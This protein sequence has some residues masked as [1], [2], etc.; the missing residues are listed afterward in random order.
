MASESAPPSRQA[1]SSFDAPLGTS[2][3]LTAVGAPPTREPD[4]GVTPSSA[5]GRLTTAAALLVLAFLAIAYGTH[6]PSP[7]PA[8]A[9]PSEFS[10]ERAMAHVQQIS[11][12]PHPSGSADHAR[13]REYVMTELRALGLTPAIQDVTG[14][15][16]RYAVAGRVQNVVVRVPGTASDGRAVLVM[17]HYDGVGAGPAAGDDGAGVA[18][19]LET[20]RAIRAGAPLA[21]DVIALF[22]D[23]EEDGLLGAAA[24][25][26][27]HPWMKDAA[28][29]LNFDSRGDEGPAYMFETGPGNLGVVRV[30]RHVSGV[31]A[32]SL[33]TAVYRQLPNDTDLSEIMPLGLQAMNFGYIGRVDHYHTSQDDPTRL[34]RGTLQ[35]YGSQMLALAR[36]FGSGPLPMS[37][38]SDAVFFDFPGLG[39]IV[40]GE[41]WALPLAIVALLLVAIAVGR[42]VRRR[43]PGWLRGIL[44][45]V[46]GTIASIVLASAAAYGFSVAIARMHASLGGTPE[47]STVYL[48]AATLLVIAVVAASYAFVRRWATPADALIGALV[49]WALLAVIVSALAPGV[50]FL[51]AWPLLAATPAA[52]QAAE[53]GRPGPASR[54]IAAFV[55]IFLF[56]PTVYGIV[57]IALGLAG[58]GTVAVGVLGALGGWLIVPLLET[59]GGA[60]RW[61]TALYALAGCVVMSCVG[62]AT[63]R[64]TDARPVGASLVYAADADGKAYV[65]GYDFGRPGRRWVTDAVASLRAPTSDAP[66]W[67]FFAGARRP[68]A[69]APSPST[70]LEAPTGTIVSDS[71]S[72]DRRHV[73][74][75]VRAAA[76]TLNV[77]MVADSGAVLASAVDGRPVDAQRYRRPSARWVLQY[78]APPESGFLLVLTM[79]AGTHPAID[80]TARSSGIPALPGVTLPARPAGVIP[81]QTGDM[82]VVHRR[83]VL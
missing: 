19:M 34:S 37:R 47:F 36:A 44:L 8:S 9:P 65:T 39:M 49:V 3:R 63:V 62:L 30:L 61:S 78:V 76:G 42:L 40:Y 72:G 73:T 20:L 24:F 71:T 50:S 4:I 25:V 55:M 43:E 26:R 33:S 58:P 21:H 16:T 82:T 60:R 51:F 1:P 35:H 48:G 14:V 31:R 11:Q 17:A 15:G 22:S 13:V 81:V 41:R 70:P 45:G 29:V 7:V 69:I 57:G 77:L 46:S 59:L 64:T 5:T 74:L 80:L 75:R 68:V 79:P 67:V 53:T 6:T 52:L 38:T 83:I 32:T 28:V 10:A 2:D 54:W 12:R 56:V 27:E 18:A 66:P 23:G